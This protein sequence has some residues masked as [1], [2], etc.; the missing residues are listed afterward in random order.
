MREAFL[1]ETDLIESFVDENPVGLSEEDLDI[2]LSWR[3]QVAGNF[4]IFRYLKK[5]TVFLSTDE[6]PITYGVVALTEPL[7]DLVGPYL[8]AWTDTVLLP[9]QGKIVYDG[10]LSSQNVMFGAG[11]RRMLNDSYRAAKQ[12]LGIVTSL[13]VEVASVAGKEPVKTT[14]KRKPR[15]PFPGRW[16]ITWMDQWDQDYVDEEVEGFIEFE[17]KGLGS[18]QFGD[19][20]GQIDYRATHRDGK[21]AVEF[22]WEGGD[23]ADGTPLTGR[24]WAVVE[25]DELNGMICIHLGEESDFKATKIVRTKK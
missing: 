4:F 18:F 24:G 22:S 2:V 11:S 5:Y 10:L 14:T 17:P 13:P 16:R 8:P 15:N 1:D 23:G 9:F 6:P 20:Q 25:G 3:H 7:E 21:P 12:G 19:V